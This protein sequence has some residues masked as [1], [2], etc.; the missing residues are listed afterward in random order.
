MNSTLYPMATRIWERRKNFIISTGKEP[1]RLYIGH[2]N[3]YE[4]L[5]E[6]APGHP[7]FI[8]YRDRFPRAFG[9]RVYM[10]CSDTDHLEVV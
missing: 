4:L 3:D 9:M 6:L 7:L 2:K 1:T 8:E 10:V 5:K